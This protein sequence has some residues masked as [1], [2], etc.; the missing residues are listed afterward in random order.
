M[1]GQFPHAPANNQSRIDQGACSRGLLR[2]MI[3]LT[4]LGGYRWQTAPR[5]GLQRHHR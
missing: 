3:H 1:L 5:L 2:Q 4:Q